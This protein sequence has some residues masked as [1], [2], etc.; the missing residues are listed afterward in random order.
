M[1]DFERGDSDAGEDI[2]PAM[3]DDER[4]R[5]LLIAELERDAAQLTDGSKLRARIEQIRIDGFNNADD[6]AALRAIAAALRIPV[7]EVGVEP[8]LLTR[9]NWPSGALFTFHDLPGA[10]DPCY[11]V[12]PG[13]AAL[14]FNHDGGEGVDIARAKFVI[15]ACNR[16]LATPSPSPE[17]EA[18]MGEPQAGYI[19]AF[20]EVADLLG[21]GARTCSPKE[22]WEGEMRPRLVTLLAGGRE[23]LERAAKA[24]RERLYPK[25][26]KSDW[27]LFAHRRGEA[28]EQAEAAI[29]ALIPSEQEKQ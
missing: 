13:G 17:R 15:A 11:V 28:C 27:T 4:A 18:S 22:A 6:R 1:N 9:C 12:M 3:T 21:I 20:Y 8:D 7:Q 5:E 19:K 29:R 25:N 2:R 10:H 24:V 16:A 26:P 23:A 14:E